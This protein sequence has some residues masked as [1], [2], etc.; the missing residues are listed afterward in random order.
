MLSGPEWLTLKVLPKT[1]GKRAFVISIPRKIV[2]LATKRNRI[3]RLLREAIRQD[4]HFKLKGKFF[5]FRVHQ[6]PGPVA[7]AD[8]KKVIQLLK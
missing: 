7:L 2:P 1:M 5:S 3:K 4:P 8:V 6:F